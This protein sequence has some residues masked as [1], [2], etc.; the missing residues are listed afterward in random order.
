M[1]LSICKLYDM[2]IVLFI[3]SK[4]IER[5]LSVNKLLCL[6]NN[7]FVSTDVIGAYLKNIILFGDRYLLVLIDLFLSSNIYYILLCRY[8][9]FLIILF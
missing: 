5:R 4:T 3:I 6:E 9:C 7:L 8:L 2:T 1:F